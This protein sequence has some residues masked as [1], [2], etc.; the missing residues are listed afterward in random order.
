MKNLKRAFFLFLRFLIAVAVSITFMVLVFEG[1]IKIIADSE[2][3][4]YILMIIPALISIL[5]LYID[6]SKKETS[7]LMW[8][9]FILMTPIIYLYQTDYNKNYLYIL[10]GLL[11]NGLGGGCKKLFDTYFGSSPQNNLST[12]KKNSSTA[13]KDT[14]LMKDNN[15]VARN[16]IMA[17]QNNSVPIAREE[18]GKVR[19]VNFCIYCWSKVN[20]NQKY[21]SNCGKQIISL[22][23]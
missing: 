10:L 8:S 11:S 16:D 18:P 22:G 1:K 7:V 2:S 6:T 15:Q 23:R 20:C 12:E 17:T 14:T 3:M 13:Q 5:I 4:S 19:E 9:N 21:C